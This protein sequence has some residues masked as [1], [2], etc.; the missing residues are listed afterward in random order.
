MSVNTV[1][2]GRP[3]GTS[4]ESGSQVVWPT[5]TDL[6]YVPGTMKVMLTLQ[7]PLIRTVLQ[8]GIENL[9]AS[10]LVEHAFPDPNLSVLF[11]RKNL[12][13]AARSHLPRANNIHRRLLVDNAY[14]DKLSRLVRIFLSS[15]IYLITPLAAR[16]HSPYASGG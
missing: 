7:L 16:S 11:I 4:I 2:G 3:I 10:L 9:R 6:I 15:I 14:L 12:V 8:D 1:P 5:E 13:G